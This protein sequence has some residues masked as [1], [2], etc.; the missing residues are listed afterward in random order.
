VIACGGTKTA[1]SAI[2]LRLRLGEI[3]APRLVTLATRVLAIRRSPS[4]SE[5]ASS[6]VPGCGHAS[7]RSAR[8]LPGLPDIVERAEDLDTPRR[9]RR[10]RDHWMGHRLRLLSDRR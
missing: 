1:R 9:N 7:S 5:R 6:E 2:W 4:V 3:A 8:G 10:L